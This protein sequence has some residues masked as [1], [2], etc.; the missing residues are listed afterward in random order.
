VYDTETNNLPLY[1]DLAGF[2][3]EYCA[4]C[5]SAT[6]INNPVFEYYPMLLQQTKVKTIVSV[7]EKNGFS[8]YEYKKSRQTNVNLCCASFKLM[9]NT[10]LIRKKFPET[11][12]NSELVI[13]SD[14]STGKGKFGVHNALVLIE[15]C[16]LYVKKYM[17]IILHSSDEEMV[18]QLSRKYEIK[19]LLTTTNIKS[20]LLSK[21]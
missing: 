6:F 9:N 12:L 15:H 2:I 18:Q 19:T 4:D 5:K 11:R 17:I 14:I 10:I 20:I 8:C 21:Y 13:V 1:E 16:F 3:N 7:Q